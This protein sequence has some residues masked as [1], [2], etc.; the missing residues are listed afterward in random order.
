[1][2]LPLLLLTGEEPLIRGLEARVGVTESRT[3]RMISFTIDRGETS[4]IWGNS[5][6][7]DSVGVIE[8][9]VFFRVLL[10]VTPATTLPSARHQVEV[11]VHV[12]LCVHLAKLSSI[13][14]SWDRAGGASLSHCLLHLPVVRGRV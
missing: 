11:S 14:H 7:V 1:M 3:V 5:E 9:A 4:F 2:H 13:H 8:E 12:D 6:V 10:D